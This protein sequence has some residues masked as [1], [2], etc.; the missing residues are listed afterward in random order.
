MVKEVL[1]EYLKGGTGY[2]PEDFPLKEFYGFLEEE[3]KRGVP[4]IVVTRTHP[5]RLQRD[6]DLGGNLIIWLSQTV[7]GENDIVQTIRPESSIKIH[8]AFEGFF[9]ENEEGFS[10]LDG[11]EYLITQNGFNMTMKLIQLLN[12]KV[13]LSDCVFLLPVNTGALKP[14][15]LGLLRREL[16]PVTTEGLCAWK[17]NL[18]TLN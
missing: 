3:A 10:M 1:G 13:M 12:E 4:L 5:K 17:D 16:F 7:S 6:F 2:L 9:L 18:E 8:M 11:G 15:E 14:H